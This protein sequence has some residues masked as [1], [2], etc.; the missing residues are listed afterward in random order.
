M[1]FSSLRDLHLHLERL[2]K[3]FQNPNQLVN[4]QLTIIDKTSCSWRLRNL[5]R[6]IFG[7]IL[8]VVTCGQC[9]PWQ[10]Y[11]LTHVSSQLVDSLEIHKNI[12]TL[13]TTTR[14]IRLFEALE[15]KQSK[16]ADT[17]KVQRSRAMAFLPP[18]LSTSVPSSHVPPF[19]YGMSRPCKEKHLD[20]VITSIANLLLYDTL[21]EGKGAKATL[22]FI[23]INPSDKEH[24]F[25]IRNETTIRIPHIRERHTCTVEEAEAFIQLFKNRIHEWD[26][27][28]AVVFLD[29]QIGN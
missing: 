17:L 22:D 4:E 21:E 25:S 19:S 8:R 6:M 10:A 20:E 16:H 27:K 29:M 23:A 14:V 18:L 28:E 2:T 15:N 9:D 1:Q 24:I 12:L 7:N 13:E 3:A 5:C 26:K 11:R